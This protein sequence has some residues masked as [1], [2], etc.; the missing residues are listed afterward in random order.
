[1]IAMLTSSFQSLP[2]LA[3]LFSVDMGIQWVGFT[4]A[5]IFRTEKFYD[6]TGS[7]TFILLSYLS[8][9]WSGNTFRQFINSHM[10]IG[11]AC[12]LGLYLFLRILKDGKDKRF[13]QAKADPMKFFTFWTIQGV[14]V[15]VTLLPTLMLNNT[16]RDVPVGIRDYVGWGMWT[17]G[18]LFEVVADAQK[19]A[20][21]AS[22]DNEGKFITT[23]LWSLSR[24][25]NYFGEILLWFGLYVSNS[26]VLRGWEQ[27]AVL[28]PVFVH[29]L[30]TRVSGIPL[31][32][33]AAD[34]KWGGQAEYEIYKRNT[35]SLIPGLW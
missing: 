28:S 21:R 10:V 24:H 1:M 35:P 25:P 15:F 23:G 27:L 3:K 31:L 26:S 17:V 33:K 32:E 30:I 7:A 11:W 13:D 19:S 22:P 2:V 9:S 5:W 12:R 20:F 14:W 4:F 34:K 18:M 6:L 29:L 16:K 8:H